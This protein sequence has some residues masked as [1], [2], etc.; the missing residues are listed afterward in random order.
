MWWPGK[1]KTLISLMLPGPFSGLSVGKLHRGLP[2]WGQNDHNR[3]HTPLGPPAPA[4]SLCP[5][6]QQEEA[7]GCAYIPQEL[8]NILRAECRPFHFGGATSAASCR[9]TIVPLAPGDI[10][11]Q[12]FPSASQ[13]GPSPSLPTEEFLRES[14]GSFVC[15]FSLGRAST[16]YPSSWDTEPHSSTGVAKMVISLRDSKKHTRA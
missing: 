1:G 10:R 6:R 15:S 8:R 3:R 14:G 16:S 13:N 5:E 7:S 11:T 9:S 4:P 12:V 2:G